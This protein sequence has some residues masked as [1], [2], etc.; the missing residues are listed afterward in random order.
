MIGNLCGTSS[1]PQY[2]AQAA[3][4]QWTAAG[5][6]ANK[7][8]LG[9]PLYGYVSQSSKTTLTGSFVDPEEQQPQNALRG[10]HPRVEHPLAKTQPKINAV[11]ASLTSW[12]GQQIPFGSIVSSG[13]LVK[14]NGTYSGSG[15][16]TEGPCLCL[17]RPQTD[18]CCSGWDNCSDTPVCDILLL[19]F[20]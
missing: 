5:A 2:S 13:A 4:S 18:Y 9:L 19:G 3:F 6:P 7:L 16:F 10:S 14:S 11:N 20:L 17:S 12:Y 8:V 15:G 1:L